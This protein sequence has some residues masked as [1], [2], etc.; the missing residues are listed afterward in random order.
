M[1]SS[2]ETSQLLIFEYRKKSK[3]LP[4]DTRMHKYPSWEWDARTD[5]SNETE[6][7]FDSDRLEVLW[8]GLYAF[9]QAHSITYFNF[10]SNKIRALLR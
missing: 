6:N 9:L 10:Q 1:L 8:Q 2:L 5:A 3:T 7:R 4:P